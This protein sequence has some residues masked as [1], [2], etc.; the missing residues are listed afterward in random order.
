MILIRSG[1]DPPRRRLKRTLR[2]VRYCARANKSRSMCIPPIRRH[3]EQ[4]HSFCL[5]YLCSSA[6]AILVRSAPCASC[7]AAAGTRAHGTAT[8]RSMSGDEGLQLKDRT[9]GAAF[10]H[11]AQRLRWSVR[12]GQAIFRLPLRNFGQRIGRMAKEQYHRG[13]R[14]WRLTLESWRR[15]RGRTI[16]CQFQDQ[17]LSTTSLEI[18]PHNS[19]GFMTIQGRP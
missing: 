15:R 6:S 12:Q 18:G 13:T 16:A 10:P 14:L 17:E 3:S 19:V 9:A 4:L 11:D 8:A 7:S 2:S 1:F 5:I